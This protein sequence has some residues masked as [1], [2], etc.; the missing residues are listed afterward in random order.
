M[1]FIKNCWYVAAWAVEVSDNSPLGRQLLDMPV[2]LFR[3]AEGNPAAMLDRCPH[4][5]A[6]LSMGSIQD[7]CIECP[8]HGLRFNAA[9]ECVHNPHGDGRIPERARVQTFPVTE[10]HQAIWFWPGDPEKA[11]PALIPS[12]DF[13]NDEYFYIASGSMHVKGNYLLEVDN[14]LDLSHIQFVHP[15]FSS[16]AVSRAAV[17]HEIDGETVWSKRDMP[18]DETPPDFIRQVF[19]VPEGPLDRWLHVHWQAP[20]YMTLYAGGVAAGKPFEEGIVSQQAHWFTPETA[21]TTHYFYAMSEPKAIGPHMAEVVK[22]GIEALKAPFEY[23]DAPIIEAQQDRIGNNDLMDL[24]PIILS[25]DAASTAAR[26]I[27]DKKIAA[28][29]VG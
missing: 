8:Y 26:K 16:P 12:F 20:S 5:F 7:N 18:G 2:L 11:D 17:K 1:S 22:Q 9:G 4:R 24:K 3:D 14:I 28:E 27:V 10:R 15:I 13:M 6:P 25:V 29:V 23:E 21:G 19:N